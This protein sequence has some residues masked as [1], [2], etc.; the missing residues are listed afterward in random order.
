MDLLCDETYESD[1]D[2]PAFEYEDLQLMQD[3]L[4]RALDAD[5]PTIGE[6]FEL[7]G[8]EAEEEA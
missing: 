4:L 6:L 5:F 3:E 8:V 7:Y 1:L 2:L